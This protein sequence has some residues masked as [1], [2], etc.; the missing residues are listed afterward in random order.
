MARYSL[1]SP[2]SDW[3]RD[4]V[5]SFSGWRSSAVIRL[6]SRPS[7][8]CY[9][10]WFIS[11]FFLN[12]QSKA[13]LDGVDSSSNDGGELLGSNENPEAVGDNTISKQFAFTSTPGRHKGEI[14]SYG[15]F[16]SRGDPLCITDIGLEQ[17]DRGQQ[18]RGAFSG[19]MAKACGA[20]WYHSTIDH[21]AV[22]I[23]KDPEHDRISMPAPCFWLGHVSNI[24][25]LVLPFR[26]VF[27]V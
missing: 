21:E 23:G 27:G 2:V 26:A 11:F 4:G 14:A 3:P 12:L 13:S 1:G 18:G 6:V 24:L 7:R 19:V 8:P 20:Q 17:P 22:A 25:C 9:I 10:L 16:I 5:T 15:L